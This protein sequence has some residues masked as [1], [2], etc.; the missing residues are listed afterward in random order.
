MQ[1][2][3]TPR[4]QRRGGFVYKFGEQAPHLLSAQ[5]HTAE[6]QMRHDNRLSIS[7]LEYGRPTNILSENVL[8]G[9]PSAAQMIHIVVNI[10]EPDT[11]LSKSNCDHSTLAITIIYSGSTCTYILD[12][13]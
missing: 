8:I 10:Y 7:G 6:A 12:M 3:S 9:M 13:R 2:L 1:W 5:Q 11:Y 4:L